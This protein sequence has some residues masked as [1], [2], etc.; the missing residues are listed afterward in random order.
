M[1]YTITFG[2]QNKNQ[3]VSVF[4]IGLFPKFKFGYPKFVDLQE[5]LRFEEM[6]PTLY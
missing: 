2:K 1:V 6:V 3:E 4:Y 5:Y